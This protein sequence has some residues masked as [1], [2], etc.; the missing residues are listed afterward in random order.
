MRFR[1]AGTAACPMGAT[2]DETTLITV[3]AGVGSLAAG[4]G[5]APGVT[6]REGRGA[7]DLISS[8][9][10]LTPDGFRR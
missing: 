2:V 3:I 7:G 5:P 9:P 4:C 8:H 6:K 10:F 1:M